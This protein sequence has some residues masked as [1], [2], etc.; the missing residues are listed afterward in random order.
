MS[1]E[2]F[3][4]HQISA[5]ATTG[6]HWRC[7]DEQRAQAIA[8]SLNIP[9]VKRGRHSY[10]SLRETYGVDFLLIAKSGGLRLE[11]E[12]TEWYFHPNMAHV[13]VRNWKRGEGDRM[14]EA[15]GLEAG[16]SILDC[17][18]G[19]GSD[20]IVS[21]YIVGATGK[22]VALEASPL[23]HAIVSYGLAHFT[24]EGTMIQEAMRRIVTK[25]IDAL[26]YLKHQPARSF[27]VVYFDP[28][29]RHPFYSS[30]AL[31]PLRS[32][33]MSA[34]LAEETVREAQR[35]A[36]KCVVLKESSLST[37]FQRLGFPIKKGGKYS[38]VRYGVYNVQEA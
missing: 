12:T 9:Y 15:M 3:I 20:A 34:P 16:M 36:R 30:P 21:S 13:R 38:R 18:M 28:M 1:I 19:L 4:P 33:A 27:D 25:Q 23:I 32:L 14:A 22:V 26:T 35:V 29:F 2:D 24:D 5:V 8:Q 7:E 11:M 31:M 6:Q 10:A 37:E 17:T